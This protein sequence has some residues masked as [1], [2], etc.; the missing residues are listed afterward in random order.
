MRDTLLALYELQ[1]IDKA[2]YALTH[3]AE[4]IPQKIHELEQSLEGFRSELGVLSTEIEVLRGEQREIEAKNAEEGD[5]HRKWKSR[6]NDIKSPREYQALSREVELGE[7][8]IRDS[9]ERIIDLMT[10]I[11]DKQAIIDTKNKTL[12]GGEKEVRSKIKALRDRQ[13]ELSV[14]AE[15]ASQG[16]EVLLKKINSRIIKRYDNVRAKRSGT[17]VVLTDKGAC[18]GCNMAVRPQQLVEMQ[19]FTTIE[20]CSVCHRIMVHESL[21]KTDAEE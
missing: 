8:Q 18:S 1:K 6:L 11:E 17:A 20:Q 10:N 9:E 3:Q 13:A 7:R 15:A 12:R 4:E 16:R 14:E 5:K 19:R 21:L 2:S